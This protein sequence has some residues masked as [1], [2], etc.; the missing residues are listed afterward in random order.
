MNEILQVND[1]DKYRRHY[2]M[3]TPEAKQF[4]LDL[5]NKKNFTFD[6]VMK[7]CKVPRKSLRR[8]YHVGCNRKKGC[9]RKTKNPEM[10]SKLV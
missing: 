3:F 2:F 5:I 8:W 9:G 10:E 6:I 7:M 1:D 4:C